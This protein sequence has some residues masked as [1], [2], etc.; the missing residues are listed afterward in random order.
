MRGQGKNGEVEM[1][2]DTPEAITANFDRFFIWPSL[3]PVLLSQV[4]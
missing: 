3:D 4:Q 1:V 2:D